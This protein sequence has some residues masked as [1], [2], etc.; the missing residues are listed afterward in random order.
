MGNR[1]KAVF[2]PAHQFVPI[3]EIRVSHPAFLKNPQFF[4]AGSAG[5]MPK[6]PDAARRTPEP[7]G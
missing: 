1:L 4:G 6:N 7:S 5:K 3:R 2:L